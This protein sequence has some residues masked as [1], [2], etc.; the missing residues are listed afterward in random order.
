MKILAFNVNVTRF[1]KSK[2][3]IAFSIFP[4]LMIGGL[5]SLIFFVDY[6]FSDLLGETSIFTMVNQYFGAVLAC[7][8]LG[9]VCLGWLFNGLVARWFLGWSKAKTRRVFLYSEVPDSW[10]MDG[11][12]AISEEQLKYKMEQWN[13]IREAGWLSF[14]FIRGA[15]GIGGFIFVANASFHLFSEQHFELSYFVWLALFWLIFGAVMAMILWYFTEKK[16]IF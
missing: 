15:L 2:Y 16:L 10:Y 9:G 14:V 6:F 7:C 5:F 3:T 11:A 13:K 1:L 8:V 12:K 4:A